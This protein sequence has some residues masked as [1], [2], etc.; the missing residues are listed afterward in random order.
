MSVKWLSGSKKGWRELGGEPW[1]NLSDKNA[2][3]VLVGFS[4]I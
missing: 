4:S 1:G 3:S 2:S